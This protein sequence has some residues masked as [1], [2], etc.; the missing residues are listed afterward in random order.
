MT[1]RDTLASRASLI[2]LA[3]YGIASLAVVAGVA[4]GWTRGEFLLYWALGAVLNVPFLAAGELVLLFH[5]PWVL[6]T[7]WLV[8][9][10]A[11]AYTFSVLR[12]ATLNE[13]SLT[14]QLPAGRDVFGLG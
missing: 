4:A 6:W 9:I 13:G 11:C 2:A 5:R 14:E 3:M 8:V 12:A 7:C 1:T 10:F